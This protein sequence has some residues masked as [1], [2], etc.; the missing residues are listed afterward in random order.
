VTIARPASRDHREGKRSVS[1]GERLTGT[2]PDGGLDPGTQRLKWALDEKAH[3]IIVS[4]KEYFGSDL[5]AHRIALAAVL[6]HY[7]AHVGCFAPN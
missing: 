1:D 4:Y 5:H 3:P 2:A 6:V 7:H